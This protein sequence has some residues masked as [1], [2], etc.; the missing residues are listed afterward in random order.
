MLNNESKIGKFFHCNRLSQV[1]HDV[2]VGDYVTFAP[3]VNCN[4]N[5][6]IGDFAY[7]GTSCILK[8]GTPD[9][10]L[11]IGKG[12]VIGMGAVVTKDVPANTT[13]IGNP[14]RIL[15]E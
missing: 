12:A 1:G 8:H 3:N 15:G 13:V 6:I 7:L 9:K 5:T 10:P 11:R 14:A 4:G 2:T